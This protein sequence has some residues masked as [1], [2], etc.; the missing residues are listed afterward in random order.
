MTVAVDISH[1]LGNFTLDARF[2][3]ADGLVALLGRS[4]SGKTSII[5]IIAGL[6]NPDHG[7]VT[8]DDVVLFDTAREIFIPRP[9]P[10]DWLCLPGGPPI[11]ASECPPEPPLRALVCAAGSE[12]ATS[13]S[14]RSLGIGALLERRPGRLSG[15]EKQRVAIGR[16]LLANPRLLLMDEPLASLDEA[17]RPRSCP[18]SNGCVIR[19]ACR[20]SMSAIRLRRL[21][22]CVHRCPCERGQGCGGRTDRTDHASPRPLPLDGPGRGWRAYRGHGGTARRAVRADGAAIP[23][24]PLEVASLDAPIG[25]R[26]RLRVRARDVM[27]RNIGA[28]GFECAQCSAAGCLRYR[29]PHM[30]R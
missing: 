2:E 21:R 11:S 20:S 30:G 9:S 17:R 7:R 28:G 19:R 4:G 22:V 10:P 15:G 1:R 27:V 24:R 25:A 5:N 16:A 29:L 13:T 23:R 26:L 8:I 18:T 3:T 14:G 6:I 12:A